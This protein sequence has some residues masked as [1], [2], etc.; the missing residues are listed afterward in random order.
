MWCL[1]V[2]ASVY[3]IT[4]MRKKYSDTCLSSSF[5]KSDAHTNWMLKN[6][7]TSTQASVCEHTQST[8]SHHA[9]PVHYITPTPIAKPTH[10]TYKSFVPLTHTHNS[11]ARLAREKMDIKKATMEMAFVHPWQKDPSPSAS[12]EHS[13]SIYRRG[14]ERVPCY[15]KFSIHQ[16][17]QM[18][19]W[20]QDPEESM[21]NWK[22]QRGGSENEHHF[23]ASGITFSTPDQGSQ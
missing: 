11:V 10:T 9:L 7:Q 17:T 12:R 16:W 5:I 18:T 4:F 14:R 6:C 13:Y 15:W 22:N 23:T 3:T 19:S 20:Y 1:Y 8:S 2:K 21:N